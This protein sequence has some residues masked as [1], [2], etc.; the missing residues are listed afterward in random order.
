[1]PDFSAQHLLP[2]EAALTRPPAHARR[3]AL[4]TAAAILLHAAVVGPMVWWTQSKPP[5]PQSAEIEISPLAESAPAEASEPTEVTEQAQAAQPETAPTETPPE[6][7]PPPPPDAVQPPPPDDA[8]PPPPEA[9]AEPSPPDTPPP[10]Q[11]APTPLIAPLAIEP[12]ESEE[13][14]PPPPP[15]DA[16]ETPPP[17]PPPTQAVPDETV[18]AVAPPPPPPRPRPVAPP[19]PVQPQEA[20]ATAAAPAPAVAAPAAP[21]RPPASYVGLLMGALERH[22]EYPFSA[23]TRRA[24]GTVVLR[25]AMRR[26]G[27]VASWRI[28]RSSGHEDLDQAVATM[29][30]RASPLP[31]P[32][33]E[34]PGDPVELVVPVR[35]TLRP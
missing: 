27:S 11:V 21:A 6:A 10:E 20:P 3:F 14:V 18:R 28:E 9:V 24:E 2:E 8:P 19:R 17:P 16:V 23:R 7:A 5:E 29:I 15:E 35:F 25:F 31:A 30:R 12:P 26:D 1:M 33:A 22:K 4:P 13:V 34:M 32:P